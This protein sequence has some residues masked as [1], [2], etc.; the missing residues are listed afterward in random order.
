M[1]ADTHYAKHLLTRPLLLTVQEH[2]LGPEPKGCSDILS[3][4]ALRRDLCQGMDAAHLHG[5][6]QLSLELFRQG[7]GAL[8]AAPPGAEQQRRDMM[9]FQQMAEL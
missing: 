2:P 9:R 4:H 1:H 3:S 7:H 5:V 6:G 8:G